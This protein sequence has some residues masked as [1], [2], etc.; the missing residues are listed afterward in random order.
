[1]V[2]QKS[3]KEC[4]HPYTQSPYARLPE[5][6][7]RNQCRTAAIQPHPLAWSVKGWMRSCQYSTAAA[8]ITM[9]SLPIA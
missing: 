7:Q 2:K 8:S 6:H 1:M 9:T 5:V 4:D 3:N